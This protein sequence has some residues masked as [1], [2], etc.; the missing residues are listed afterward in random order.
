VPG[1]RLALDATFARDGRAA[2]RLVVEAEWDGGAPAFAGTTDGLGQVRLVLPA[3]PLPASYRLV[4]GGR[5]A[6]TLFLEAGRRPYANPQPGW[7]VVPGLATE[8]L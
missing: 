8:P 3:R 6:G 4:V 2:V 7:S 5:P 1:S